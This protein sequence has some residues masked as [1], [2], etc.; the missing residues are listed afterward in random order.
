MDSK[1]A[2]YIG[3]A[4]R[5]GGVIYGEDRICENIKACHA[6]LICEEAP[7]KYKQ[8]LSARCGDTKC[9][10]VSGLREAAHRDNIQAIGITNKD[11]AAAMIGLL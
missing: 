5:S 1:L 9:F 2:S 4:Q 7:D 8:R 11:L 3:L 10:I 6:V